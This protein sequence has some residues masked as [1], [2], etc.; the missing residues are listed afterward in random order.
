MPYRRILSTRSVLAVF[1]AVLANFLTFNFANTFMPLYVHQQFGLSSL[2]AGLFSAAVLLGQFLVKMGTG[3]L[4]DRL[5]QV[6]ELSKV[7]E[8]RE[9]DKGVRLKFLCL[10]STPFY[11]VS[12]D[13]R[14]YRRVR[15]RTI[16][17]FP[18]V[19]PNCTVLYY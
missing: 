3:A 7:G 1:G 15:N 12:F 19:Y 6:P 18:M 10:T 2:E 8:A 5:R 16:M 13:V 17:H 9:F 11:Y 4:T 14:E